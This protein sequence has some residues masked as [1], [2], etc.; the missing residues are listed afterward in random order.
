[1]QCGMVNVARGRH[2]DILADV[3][4]VVILLNHIS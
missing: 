1:M 3:I 4:A 2:D